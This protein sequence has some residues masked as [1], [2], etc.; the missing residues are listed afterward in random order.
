MAETFLPSARVYLQRARRLLAR[1]ACRRISAN[2]ASVRRQNATCS[3]CSTFVTRTPDG[4]IAAAS[5]PTITRHGARTPTPSRTRSTACCGCRNA[6]R[7]PEGSEAVLVAAERLLERLERSRTLRRSAESQVAAAGVV[8][9]SHRQR[10]DRVA[11]AAAGADGGRRAIRERGVQG[12]RRGEARAV[13]RQRSAG[14]RGGVAGSAPI[15]GAYIPFAFPNWA[16]KFFID[17]LCAKRAWLNAASTAARRSR[18]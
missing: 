13:A 6:C 1:R 18:A 15:G 2:L 16:A 11:L 3:G 7:S 17:A 10:A 12:D 9:L 14:I 5:P 4:S 8:R